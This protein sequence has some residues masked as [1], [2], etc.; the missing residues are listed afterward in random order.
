METE[1][2][3]KTRDRLE[4]ETETGDWNGVWVW[5]LRRRLSFSSSLSHF[6]SPAVPWSRVLCVCAVWCVCVC[7]VA[8]WLKPGKGSTRLPVIQLVMELAKD[9]PGAPEFFS[10]KC[11]DRQVV[12]GPDELREFCRAGN[13]IRG[14][15]YGQQGGIGSAHP[16]RVEIFSAWSSGVLNLLRACVRNKRMPSVAQAKQIIWSGEL[17]EFADA[18]GGF[19]I[20]DTLLAEEERRNEEGHQ[21]CFCCFCVCFCSCSFCSF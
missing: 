13:V 6:L 5:R 9:P 21:V 17:R 7:S 8:L 3:T 16:P 19:A 10:F 11:S 20:V 2:E 12:I 14:L 15:I 4:T 1:T 18:L